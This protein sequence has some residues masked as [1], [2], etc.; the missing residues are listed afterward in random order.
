MA[1]DISLDIGNT[2]AKGEDRKRWIK[3]PSVTAVESGS[4]NFDGLGDTSDDIVYGFEGRS[5]V[6]GRSAY[7]LG[8][9]QV[10]EMGQQRVGSQAYRDLI[11]GMLSQLSSRSTDIRIIASLPVAFYSG[12]AEEAR[13]VYFNNGSWRVEVDGKT[14]VYKVKRSDVHIVPE[15]FGALCSIFLNSAGS[16]VDTGVIRKKIAVVDVGGRVASFIMF[17]N[18]RPVRALS[19]GIEGTGLSVL[20][21]NLGELINS[22]WSRSLTE[23][24]LDEALYTRVFKLGAERVSIGAEI[25]DARSALASRVAAT[26]NSMWD[27]GNAAEEIIF[28]GGGAPHI[29]EHMRYPHKTLI[30]EGAHNV[31]PHMANVSGALR[32]LINQAGS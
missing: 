4:L 10:L 26:I 3:F 25:D 29:F 19:R 17:E 14:R 32:F 28:T 22:K 11:A 23:L 27:N 30:S 20:W 31:T 8:R 9:L 1:K 21:Q 13:D 6:A 2:W 15:G 24:E 18:L 7:E 12:S 5:V 16:I